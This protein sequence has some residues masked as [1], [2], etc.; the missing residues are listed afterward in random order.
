MYSCPERNAIQE[1]PRASASATGRRKRAGNASGSDKRA[2]SAIPWVPR[3]K[4]SK[5]VG[6][7]RWCDGES[8]S[9]F[10]RLGSLNSGTRTAQSQAS[11]WRTRRVRSPR[12]VAGCESS[13]RGGRSIFREIGSRS[14]AGGG[15]MPHRAPAGTC[16][17]FVGVGA[18]FSVRLRSRDAFIWAG[19]SGAPTRGD[20][21]QPA[22]TVRTHWRVLSQGR[23]RSIWVCCRGDHGLAQDNYAI[24]VCCYRAH[25]ERLLQRG[26]PV[27]QR[28]GKHSAGE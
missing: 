7:S 9:C 14:G 24:V 10:W 25:R 13:R 18:R 12:A 6:T 2:A 23:G 8:M 3:R 16:D 26:Q 28:A 4:F 1:S 22:A 17:G 21:G 19:K 11:H 27:V 20:E 15:T 5:C